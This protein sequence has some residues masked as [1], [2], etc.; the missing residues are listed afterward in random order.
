MSFVE[1]KKK[2]SAGVKLDSVKPSPQEVLPNGA[3]GETSRSAL[4]L[5][6]RLPRIHYIWYRQPPGKLQHIVLRA[7]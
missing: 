3:A 6:V 5:A 2:N 7:A 1:V 4:V